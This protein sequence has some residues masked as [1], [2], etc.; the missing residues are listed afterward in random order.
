M[1]VISSRSG[2]DRLVTI[3][4]NLIREALTIIGAALLEFRR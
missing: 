3:C 2:A 4:H 1:K